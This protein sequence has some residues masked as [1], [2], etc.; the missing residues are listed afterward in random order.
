MISNKNIVDENAISEIEEKAKSSRNKPEKLMWLKDAGLGLFVHYSLDVQLG[1]VI[2]HTLVGASKD[3]TDRYFNELHKTFNPQNIDFDELARLA[4]VCGFAYVVFTAKHHNGFCFWDTKTCDFS[5]MNTPY[6]R[7]LL[8]DY[9]AAM[10]R[11]DLKVGL[12]YS[13]E[14]FYFLYKNNLTITRNPIEPSP[15]SPEIMKQY[16]EYADAQLTELLT[17]Y[18]EIDLIFYDGKLHSPQQFCVDRSWELQENILVTRGAIKTPEQHLPGL[19][20]AS[21]EPWEACLTMGIAWQYQ[22]TNE[23][24]KSGNKLIKILTESRAK[25]GTMLLNISFDSN[26]N[27]P[28]IQDDIL[29]EFGAWNFIN[30]EVIESTRPWI[31]T[32]EDDIWFVKSKDQDTIYAIIR[33]GVK[34]NRGDRR[35]FILKSV[36]ATEKTELSVLGQ[37]S[38]LTEY[39]P[40]KDVSCSFKNTKDGL[41]ISIAHAQRIYCGRD[42]PNPIVA[43]L[44]NVVPAYIPMVVLDRPENIIQSKGKVTLSSSIQ[45]MGSLEEAYVYFR[46]RKYPGFANALSDEPYGETE[47]V[48]VTGI[49]D[50]NISITNLEQGAIYQYKPVAES[51]GNCFYGDE[52]RFTAL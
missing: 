35:N 4:K 52:G 19:V 41:E 23:N 46:Y 12:Y 49:S 14:D 38:E 34:W 13:P 29:R 22:P 31:V 17:N 10:R 47:K 48:K 21:D 5:I 27:I 11:Y 51:N 9:V 36:R 40:T 1:V 44:T 42:W 8:A 30:K 20:E 28:Q 2:S 6:A 25:G 37:S 18:G 32:N 39:N 50:I 7:D 24:Y 15:Y 43:K 26:G 45:S 33:D 3:Y 16:N